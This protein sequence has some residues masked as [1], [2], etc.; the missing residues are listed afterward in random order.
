MATATTPRTVERVGAYVDNLL[1]PCSRTDILV[2]AEQN[3]APD[4]IL[5]AIEDLP[6]RK[7]RNLMDITSGLEARVQRP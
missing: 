4:L 7:Y 1:F 5:D 2:C 6:A 3:E